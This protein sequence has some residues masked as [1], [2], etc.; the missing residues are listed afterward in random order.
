M[1]AFAEYRLNL[2]TKPVNLGPYETS[3]VEIYA[4]SSRSGG[5][6][7]QDQL[8][9]GVSDSQVIQEDPTQYQDDH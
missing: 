8:F 2:C 1:Q 9:G 3:H 6:S 7:I 4:R 5:Q